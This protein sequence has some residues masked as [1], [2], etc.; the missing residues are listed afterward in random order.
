M[1]KTLEVGRATV[2]HA[3]LNKIKIVNAKHFIARGTVLFELDRDVPVQSEPDRTVGV[4]KAHSK[5]VVTYKL[6]GHVCFRRCLLVS[7]MAA[8][9]NRVRVYERSPTMQRWVLEKHKID[10]ITLEEKLAVMTV[11]HHAHPIGDLFFC[12]LMNGV[13]M[14]VC[15]ERR[16]ARYRGLLYRRARAADEAN[17]GKHC[18][19]EYMDTLNR[20]SRGEL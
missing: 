10:T 6:Q 13:S 8:L 18:D 15:L 1:A 20:L 5:V 12:E 9:Q 17:A 3:R 4:D 19:R 2:E 11:D 16:K 7:V 14:P